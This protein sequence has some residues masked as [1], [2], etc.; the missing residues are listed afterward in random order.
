VRQYA[1][2]MSDEVSGYVTRG[3]SQVREMT[4]DHEGTAVLVA[5]AAGF[6][7]GLLLGAAMASSHSR[8]P[9]WRERIAAEG[10]G[11]RL[12]QRVESMMPDALSEF[13]HR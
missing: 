1:N 11:R 2:E 4:R 7:V 10:L 13:V 3:A 8:P 5:L 12:L 9:T 6:G